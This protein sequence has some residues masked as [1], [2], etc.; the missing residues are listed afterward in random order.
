MDVIARADAIGKIFRV[1][2]DVA[3]GI[4]ADLPAIVDDDVFVAGVFMR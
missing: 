4:A 3:G 1:N 2:D